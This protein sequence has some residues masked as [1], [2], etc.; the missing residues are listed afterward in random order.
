[1]PLRRTRSVRHLFRFL[2]AS[3]AGAGAA[4]FPARNADLR[5]MPL[6]ACTSFH[7]LHNHAGFY[8]LYVLTEPSDP[9]GASS[10]PTARL[11][12]RRLHFTAFSQPC[13]GNGTAADVL[14]KAAITSCTLPVSGNSF[15]GPQA[16]SH[17]VNTTQQPPV[18]VL[19]SP[20][21]Q[22]QETAHQVLFLPSP[23]QGFALV[24]FACYCNSSLHSY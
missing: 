4:R 18:G 16:L 13:D 1:M 24:A 19:Q 5:S 6:L 20:A 14:P 15:H 11:H 22:L 7:M 2:A 23:C 17:P 10:A 3:L 12:T 9:P 21:R 8:C